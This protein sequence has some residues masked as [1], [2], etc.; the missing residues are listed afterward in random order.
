MRR[1]AL[2]TVASVALAASSGASAGFPGPNG[3]IAF[4][5]VTPAGTA[6]YLVD[7]DGGR[8]RRLAAG[9]D[10]SFSPDGTRIAFES[11][12]E[13]VVAGVDGGEARPVSAGEDPAWSPDGSTIALVYR[14]RIV[15]VPVDGGAAERVVATGREPAWSPDGRRIAFES[16]G[17]VAV[18]GIDGRGRAVVARGSDPA[19]SPDGRLIAFVRDADVMLVEPNAGAERAVTNNYF[20]ER[21]PTF[22]PD[23]RSVLFVSNGDVC[24]GELPSPG[25]EIP[26]HRVHRLTYRPDRPGYFHA[27]PDW[28]RGH[29]PSGPAPARAR[30]DDTAPACGD[31][32]RAGGAD[33]A[34]SRAGWTASMRFRLAN[35]GSEPETH[36]WVGSLEW[37]AAF[38]S[39]ETTKGTC[40]PGLG[41]AWSCNV[42]T[43]GP[44]E[45]AV[46]E[47]LYRTMREKVVL[48]AYFFTSGAGLHIAYGPLEVCSL[49]GTAGDDH[50]VGTNRDDRICGRGG[51]DDV[52]GRGGKD[53]LDGGDGADRLAGGPGDDYVQGG[54]DDDVLSGDAGRD[55]LRGGF[56]DDR[57]L[58]RDRRADVVNGEDGYDR[59]QIDPGLRDRVLGV[60][61]L[62]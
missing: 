36:V 11:D 29:A 41:R 45:S 18:A 49:R 31:S 16:G 2:A 48:G 25:A 21:D 43:L 40:A 52:R 30:G 3:V 34:P 9:A 35:T 5:R 57:L 44:G 58:A 13:V 1:L 42:G 12:G 37:D 22:S 6:I 50:L 8:E 14:G 60:E 46:V 33:Q 38:V 53:V 10:P 62:F 4:T 15:L 55:E 20:G 19:W 17:S 23:G 61:E 39:V 24:I 54:N 47:A 56:G 28:Q 59:A 7:P 26:R 32:F 27:E 51:D